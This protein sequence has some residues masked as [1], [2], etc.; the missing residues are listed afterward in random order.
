MGARSRQGAIALYAA[1][2]VVVLFLASGGLLA[3]L[4]AAGA[5]VLAAALFV[6]RSGEPRANRA[7][8]RSQRGR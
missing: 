8:R 2:A 4:L 1:F 3:L 5:V 6:L 7:E